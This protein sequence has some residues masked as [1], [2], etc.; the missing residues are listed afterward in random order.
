MADDPR[1]A[2][3][4]ASA[5]RLGADPL[6]LATVI[7]YETGGTFSPSIFGGA[8]KRHMGLIQFGPA[9]RQQYGASADQSFEDQLPAVERYLTD[10]GFKPGMGRLDLYSTI[11]AGQPGRYG[12]SDAGNGGAP[13]SVADKVRDQM[14][15]HEAKASAFLGGSFTPKVPDA[16]TSLGAF[17]LAGPTAA[18]TPD[19]MTPAAGATMQAPAAKADDG[20]DVAKLLQALAGMGGKA[21]ATAQAAAAP[22]PAPLQPVRRAAPTFDPTAYLGMLQRSTRR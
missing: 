4:I 15:P 17:G 14:G 11:N 7:S 9:E 1:V 22:A 19:S 16:P 20:P 13:G 12:A 18:G 6:D 8:G 2:A 10:R 3:L 21:P 5:S